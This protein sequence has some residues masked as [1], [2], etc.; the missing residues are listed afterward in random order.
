[1]YLLPKQTTTTQDLAPGCAQVL[2]DFIT[3]GGLQQGLAAERSTQASPVPYS[4]S[5]GDFEQ[6]SVAAFLT[7][8]Q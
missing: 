5:L 2:T 3:P 7:R 6:F 4:L 8:K 1:M